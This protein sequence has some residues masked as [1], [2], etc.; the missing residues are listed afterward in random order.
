LAL[1]VG[2]TLAFAST[3]AAEIPPSHKVKVLLTALS[4]DKSLKTRASGK[5]VIGVLGNCAT[6]TALQE[7]SGKAINGL[8][9]AVESLGEWKSGSDLEQVL[10]KNAVTVLFVCSVPGD[11]WGALTKAANKEKAVTLAEDASWVEDKLALG[12][13]EKNGR[14][15]LVINLEA[16]RAAGAEFDARIFGVARVVQ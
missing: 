12:V 14:A 2:A 3:A 13:G 15:E 10:K 8:P 6:T 9:I 16:A 1:S 11:S 5:I 4:F 7:A